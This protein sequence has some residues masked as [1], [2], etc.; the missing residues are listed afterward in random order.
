MR[1]I[2][3]NTLQFLKRH[4]EKIIL[5]LVLLGLA[6]AA[7]LMGGKINEVKSATSDLP[8]EPSHP[9][10][11]QPLDLS[12]D[13]AVLSAITNP[14]P[15]ILSGDHNLFNPVTWRKMPNGELKKFVLIGPDALKLTNEVPQYATIEYD[16]AS[17]SGVYVLEVQQHSGRKLPEYAKKD[18]VKK[19]RIYVI[20]GIKGA[21]DNPDALELEIPETG[22]TVS[23]SKDHPY[24]RVDGY[25][26]DLWYPPDSKAF[27]NQK[28]DQTFTLDG[29]Q[30][31]IVEMTNN[32][33]RV[34]SISNGKVTPVKWEGH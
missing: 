25:L 31:K 6:A 3:H 1:A 15:V 21:V 2:L 9:K 23:I 17:G 16:H 27:L 30:Y 26:A 13:V 7:V 19:N 11:L 14:P 34:Q 12:S 20:R 10:P 33:I 8:S 4:Y 29:E 32:L 5:C 24:Q 28:L 18:E 22:E